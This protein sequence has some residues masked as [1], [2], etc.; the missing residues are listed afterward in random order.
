MYALWCLWYASHSCCIFRWREKVFALLVQIKSNEFLQ[1]ESHRRFAHEKSDLTEKIN[2][3]RRD[4]DLLECS[5]ED[6]TAQLGIEQERSKTLENRI[7]DL[8]V[9]CSATA[10]KNQNLQGLLD[11]LSAL[12]R[13]FPVV[14]GQ[15]KEA[16]S[17][18]LARL[19]GYERRL[20]F[21]YK[22]IQT[23]QGVLVVYCSL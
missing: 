4:R 10:E 3:L 1:Q 22:R 8:V 6:R 16:L 7:T 19:V 5:L 18:L 13:Q 9:Q 20:D 21:A 2:H 15:H 17:H 12:I 14:A 11:S 23:F